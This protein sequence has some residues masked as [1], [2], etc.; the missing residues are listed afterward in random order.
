MRI[1]VLIFQPYIHLEIQVIVLFENIKDGSEAHTKIKSCK[2]V[3]GFEAWRQLRKRFHPVGGPSSKSGGCPA[4]EV[5]WTVKQTFD[6][7]SG[8]LTLLAVIRCIFPTVWLGVP[9][10]GAMFCSW[11]G[12]LFCMSFAVGAFCRML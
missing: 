4:A 3:G 6:L 7:S 12:A 2:N 1:K 5:Y 11:F 10:V 9:A 8:R